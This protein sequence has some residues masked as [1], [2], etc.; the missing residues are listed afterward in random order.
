MDI[1]LQNAELY[2][3]G[4]TSDIDLSKFPYVKMYKGEIP[5]DEKFD[6]IVCIGGIL[7][8]QEARIKELRRK[9]DKLLA[10]GTCSVWGCRP[11]V[12]LSAFNED[13]RNGVNE[14]MEENVPDFYQEIG[15]ITRKTVGD[16]V[17]FDYKIPGCPI[18]EFAFVSFLMDLV[19]GKLPLIQEA[20]V[21]YECKLNGNECIFMEKGI[22]CLG[23]ITQCGCGAR[24]ITLG[25]IETG[26]KSVCTGCFG[27]LADANLDEWYKMILRYG[28]SVENIFKFF[29]AR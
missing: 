26:L 12:A 27:P 29:V 16:V 24:C 15:A 9:S 19:E 13:E 10:L 18:N 25:E 17:D 21:C 28:K 2:I 5:E 14:K 23:P 7:P 1:V 6:V 22:V 11:T 4:L 20:P 8:E 3:L